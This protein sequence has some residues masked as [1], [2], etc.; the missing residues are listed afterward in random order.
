MGI[1]KEL[2]VQ[3]Q[4]METSVVILERKQ[5]GGKEGRGLGGGGEDSERER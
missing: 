4:E 5:E 2:R 1:E 3:W